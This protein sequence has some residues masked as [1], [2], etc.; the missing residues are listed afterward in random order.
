[1]IIEQD[2]VVSGG[3]LG[4]S[5]LWHFRKLSLTDRASGR[6][7]EFWALMSFGSRSV[8]ERQ[9]L[10]GLSA[11]QQRVSGTPLTVAVDQDAYRSALGKRLSSPDL[12]YGETGFV[13]ATGTLRLRLKGNDMR[14]AAIRIRH[15][16]GPSV[17]KS[18]WYQ[19]GQEGHDIRIALSDVV[20]LREMKDIFVDHPVPYL[21]KVED[22]KFR[23]PTQP[24]RQPA[25]A[26]AQTV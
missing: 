10:M 18:D 12:V 25:P 20:A 1:M 3:A 11:M 22:L 21:V 2:L 6:S 19:K 14:D 7:V 8:V 13:P 24:Q 5:V 9:G 17:R 16:S 26:R 4:A 23:K 15:M